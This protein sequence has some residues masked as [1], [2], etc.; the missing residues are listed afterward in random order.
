MHTSIPCNA[1][2]VEALDAIE[3]YTSLC[4]MVSDQVEHGAAVVPPLAACMSSPNR[5]VSHIPA[6]CCCSGRHTAKDL[7]STC[8]HGHALHE[9]V[10]IHNQGAAA[11]SAD[12]QVRVDGGRAM[13]R[14]AADR[15]AR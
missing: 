6:S 10:I 11:D 4:D 13:L 8:W 15:D 9:N 2:P 1:A 5:S 7:A 12:A 3:V 14:L